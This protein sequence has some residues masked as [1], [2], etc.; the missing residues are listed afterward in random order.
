MTQGTDAAKH[1]R[2]GAGVV[3]ACALKC[4][5]GH[6]QGRLWPRSEDERQRALAAGYDLDQILH[7]NDLCT[8]D[9][10]R[11]HAMHDAVASVMCGVWGSGG[12]QCDLSSGLDQCIVWYVGLICRA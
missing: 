10:V 6:I 11:R 4:M 9:Q 8:G 7:T 3:A 1:T 2:V 12:G 5:G